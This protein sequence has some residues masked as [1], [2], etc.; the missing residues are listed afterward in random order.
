ML[1]EEIKEMIREDIKRCEKQNEK[2]EGSQELFE[3]LNRKYSTIFDGFEYRF[4]TNVPISA[5]G[6]FYFRIDVNGI[7]E[8][9]E[10]ILASG[11]S[12]KSNSSTN[13]NISN[14]NFN[15][16][17]MNATFKEVKYNIQNM[18]SLSEIET[19]ETLKKVNE[20]E[21][22]VESNES[23]KSKWE[24]AKPIL[25]WLADK[26]VDVGIQLLPL[27]LKIGG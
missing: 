5:V 3:G 6:E 23:R 8:T 13:F 21:I 27:I 11:K 15:Q 22:I 26:S 4:A 14:S 7:K 25:K 12:P 1:N 19:E 20:I 16:I 24:K 17:T 18:C 2:K 10:A 9:L